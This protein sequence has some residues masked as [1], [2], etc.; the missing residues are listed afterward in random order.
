MIE[1]LLGEKIRMLREEAPMTQA[2][3]ANELG[4]SRLSIG[5]YEKGDRT[6]DIAT[7]IKMA[8]LF[9]CS[10]D[11]LLELSEAKNPLEKDN[12]DDISQILERIEVIIRKIGRAHV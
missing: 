4:L 1:N 6:P 2:V 11:Y 10:T 3:L 12:N 7:I 9:H 5:N 8:T